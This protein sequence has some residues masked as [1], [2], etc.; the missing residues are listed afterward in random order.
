[1]MVD[2][3]SIPGA[4]LP[5]QWQLYLQHYREQTY[6]N[7]PFTEGCACTPRAMAA[8]GF[9]HCPGENSP[10]VAQCFFCFKELEGWEP[11]DDPM[12]EHRK[13]SSACA[14]LTLKKKT[15]DLTLCEFLRLDK[16][17][18]RNKIQKKYTQKIEQFQEVAKQVRSSIEKLGMDISVTD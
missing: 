10:D 3:A 6:T 5:S 7:W 11:D 13:H 9:I 12:D 18:T 14:F 8:A 15:E 17:R 4:S 1:M 16:E 2:A